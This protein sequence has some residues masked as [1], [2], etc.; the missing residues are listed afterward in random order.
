MSNVLITALAKHYVIKRL[1]Y[2]F[3]N[4]VPAA[5]EEKY[6]KGKFFL[7]APLNLFVH[8]IYEEMRKMSVVEKS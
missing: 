6:P 4:L 2:L 8:S 5:L 3:I 7:Q 1:L